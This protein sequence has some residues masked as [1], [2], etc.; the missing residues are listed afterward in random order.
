MHCSTYIMFPPFFAFFFFCKRNIAEKIN[1][2]K[3]AMGYARNVRVL[4]ISTKY[5]LD[6]N[7][8]RKMGTC[9]TLESS[10]LVNELFREKNLLSL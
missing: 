8:Y 7:F 2:L 3:I 4:T 10:L 5:H 6:Q 1:N 9:I